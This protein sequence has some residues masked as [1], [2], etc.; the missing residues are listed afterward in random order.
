MGVVWWNVGVLQLLFW[1]VTLKGVLTDA[2][3]AFMRVLPPNY[4]YIWKHSINVALP[5]HWA[6]NKV[7][8]VHMYVWAESIGQKWNFLYLVYFVSVC[9]CVICANVSQPHYF[10]VVITVMVDALRMSHLKWIPIAPCTVRGFSALYIDSDVD[11]I[12]SSSQNLW[13][14]W[15]N[16]CN[17]HS[18]NY[19]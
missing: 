19:G 2:V 13:D 15:C 7:S 17:S 5:W 18:D 11:N 3:H 16:P 14:Y 10:K 6:L 8:N 1:R 9:L 12:S 4:I